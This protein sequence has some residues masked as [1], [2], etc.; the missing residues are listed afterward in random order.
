MR[1]FLNWLVS[2]AS[3]EWLLKEQAN[4]GDLIIARSLFASCLLF[5]SFIALKHLLDPGRAWIFSVAALQQEAHQSLPVFGALLAAVYATLYTRFA[6]Q[7][8]YL[9]GLFNQIV[10]AE[11]DLADSDS[12]EKLSSLAWWKAAFIEDAEELHLSTKRIF[13]PA[14]RDWLGDAEVKTEFIGSV[15]GGE[16]RC[17]SLQRRLAQ[18]RMD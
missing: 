13:V 11:I 16:K 15:L 9:A 18:V 3:G 10:Q 1:A 7:W 12:H 4:G 14:I 2:F 5:L 8:N 17:E 6:A